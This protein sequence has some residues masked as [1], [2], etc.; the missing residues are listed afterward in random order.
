MD[1]NEI[2]EQD[3]ARTAATQ[4]EV[5]SLCKQMR[6]LTADPSAISPA[7]GIE[8]VRLA[9]YMLNTVKDVDAVS[10]LITPDDMQW[11]PEVWGQLLMASTREGF[12]DT[13]YKTFLVRVA[14][15]MG[16]DWLENLR[17]D[18]AFMVKVESF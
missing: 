8:M 15:H 17:R 16:P 1:M 11:S 10:E 4:D 3:D 12:M 7:A 6:V 2:V 14:S 18:V 13:E 5:F 9:V